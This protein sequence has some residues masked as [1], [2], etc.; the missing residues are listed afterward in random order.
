MPLA[1]IDLI[2]QDLDTSKS[3]KRPATRTTRT[4]GDPATTPIS[5]VGLRLIEEALR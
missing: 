2:L 4:S 3:K 5:R 1:L